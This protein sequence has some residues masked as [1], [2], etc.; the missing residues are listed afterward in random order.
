M[1]DLLEPLITNS[2]ELH[3]TYDVLIG[4]DVE[5]ERLSELNEQR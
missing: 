5:D 4:M 2:R 1:T 3:S